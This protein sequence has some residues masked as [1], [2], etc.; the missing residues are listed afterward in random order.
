MQPFLENIRGKLF[1]G[2][3]V[4]K[5]R[6]R[7]ENGRRRHARAEQERAQ[8]AAWAN[9]TVMRAERM[10]MLQELGD[11]DGA[12]RVPDGA[13]EAAP[14][15]LCASADG[16]EMITFF[17]PPLRCSDAFSIVVKMPVDSHTMSAPVSPH[18]TSDGLRTA[19]NLIGLP[20]MISVLDASSKSTVPL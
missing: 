8:D 20:S 2:Q 7:K 1:H 17:A 14:L 3:A 15:R 10:R 6:Q 4:D 18:G 16:A 19:K 13:V 11:G 12:P 5:Y 9:K